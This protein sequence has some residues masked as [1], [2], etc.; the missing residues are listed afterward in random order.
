MTLDGC[1]P[2]LICSPCYNRLLDSSSFKNMCIE[3]N[4]TLQNYLLKT[5]CE[6]VSVNQ[7]NEIISPEICVSSN[8]EEMKLE[9]QDRNGVTGN[10]NT[11]KQIPEPSSEILSALGLIPVTSKSE[12]NNE[13]DTEAINTSHK[14]SKR[15]FKC[16][17]CDYKAVDYA[18][19]KRH[20]V[21]HGEEPYTCKICGKRFSKVRALKEHS[22]AS[23][24]GGTPYSC[25]Q[26][27]ARFSTLTDLTVHIRKHSGNTDAHACPV[28][29]RRFATSKQLREHSATHEFDRKPS[30]K[31]KRTA[32]GSGN[33]ACTQCE[34]RFRKKCDLERHE[35]VHSGAKPYSCPICKGRFQQAHNLT[36]HMVTHT[37]VK[38]YTCDICHKTFGRSDVLARHMH[39]HEVNKPHS[40]EF[41]NRTFARHSQL[42]SHL[43][44]KHPVTVKAPMS[45]K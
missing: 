19:Y 32:T 16:R 21:R 1:L 29:P 2:S 45:P 12:S 14:K 28:C 43:Q 22:V 37:G 7:A 5:R 42:V 38:S 33:H 6:S 4:N 39:V 20:L 11:V 15:N 40:C 9:N 23:H 35:R 17:E 36:K 13:N 25:R 26:C 3:T 41:C 18:A 8:P 10:E 34:R 24:S 30:D 44:K 31:Y 27:P